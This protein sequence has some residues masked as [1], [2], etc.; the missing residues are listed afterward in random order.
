MDTIPTAIEIFCQRTTDLMNANP[1]N[2][3]LKLIIQFLTFTPEE[4]SK[5]G[6]TP[7]SLVVKKKIAEYSAYAFSIVLPLVDHDDNNIQGLALQCVSSWSTHSTIKTESLLPV[8][9]LVLQKL[10]KLDLI[11]TT[12]EVLIVL[13]SDNEEEDFILPF[14]KL[15]CKF[16]EMYIESLLQ[17]LSFASQFF[18]MLIQVTAYPALYPSNSDISEIPF[19]FWFAFEDAL[20]SNT[21]IFLGKTAEFEAQV[22]YQGR[23][24]LA[25]VLEILYT[26]MMYPKDKALESALYCLKAFSESIP[27]EESDYIPHIFSEKA[28]QAIQKLI[29]DQIEGFKQLRTTFSSVLGNFAEWLNIHPEPLSLCFNFLLSEMVN[30]HAPMAAAAALT[31]ICSVCQVPLSNYADEILNLCMSTLPNVHKHVQGK[32][33][34]SLSYIIQALPPSEAAPRLNYIIIGILDQI[35][36]D[37]TVR[38]NEGDSEPL[39]D[40]LLF[41]LGF[42]KS[43][44]KGASHHSPHHSPTRSSLQDIV[45]DEEE[46]QLGNRFVQVIGNIFRYWVSDLSIVI[47]ICII[48]KDAFKSE[49]KFIKAQSKIILE[50]IS[51]AFNQAQH[52]CL[53]SSAIAVLPAINQSSAPNDAAL[54]PAC[55]AICNTFAQ[56]CTNLSFMEDNSD[57]VHEFYEFLTWLLRKCPS[58]VNDFQ[59]QF[60]EAVFRDC[61]LVG[62]LMADVLI[63]QSILKFLRELL[64]LGSEQCPLEG[65]VQSILSQIGKPVFTQ[66]LTGIGG[67]QAS[68]VVPKIADTL[69]CFLTHFPA[70]SQQLLKICLADKGFP[71]PK[72]SAEDKENFQKEIL[73]TRKSK[74]FKEAVRAFSLKCRGLAQ[75]TK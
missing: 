36:G 55:I 61:I 7:E 57:V 49:I 60:I 4:A 25:K 73:G 71:S 67:G 51:E 46:T 44:C 34:Q 6:N 65:F 40:T 48:L 1:S 75:L 2:Y 54:Y 41:H 45:L 12:S 9:N 11:E 66:L 58:I 23:Q 3:Y 53:L 18:E 15:L 63:L 72:V 27:S 56:K 22:K 32:I 62:L 39:R 21:N 31:E 37:I 42:L 5:L 52:A 43:F 13:L 59:S 69:L 20:D 70:A 33:I 24:I 38:E 47:E 26:S 28:I 64:A 29:N 50:F 19:Y 8:L 10:S 68:S 14:S 16:G 74:P 30:S 35:A 17:N